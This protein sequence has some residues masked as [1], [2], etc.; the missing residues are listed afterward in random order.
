MVREVGVGV[1]G[2]GEDPS[3]DLE[4]ASVGAGEGQEEEVGKGWPPP[5][6]SNSRSAW[7]AA[8]HGV[9]FCCCRSFWNLSAVQPS[10]SAVA[11]SAHCPLAQTSNPQYQAKEGSFMRH[12]RCGPSS[13]H[14][15]VPL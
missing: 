3:L 9:C 1:G 10:G 15:D 2:L 13:L 12:S 14:G 7:R 5:H 8:S 11:A 4:D 6:L